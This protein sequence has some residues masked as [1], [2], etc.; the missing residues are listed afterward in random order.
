MN[1]ANAMTRSTGAFRPAWIVALLASLALFSSAAVV[2]GQRPAQPT[3]KSQKNEAPTPS[4]APLVPLSAASQPQ[5]TAVEAEALR[6]AAASTDKPL[7]G[8]VI[9]IEAGAGGQ[10]PIKDRTNLARV[11]SWTRATEAKANQRVAQVAQAYLEH[12]GAKVV[13]FYKRRAAN[14]PEAH[15]GEPK[16]DLVLNINHSYSVVPSENVTAAYYCPGDNPLLEAAARRINEALSEALGIPGTGPLPAPR[17]VAEKQDAPAVLL[18]LSLISNPDEFIHVAETSY[19]LRE[20]EAI[21]RG[22]INFARERAGLLT[23]G[24]PGQQLGTAPPW[25]LPPM[26]LAAAL[27]PPRPIEAVSSPAAS[28]IAGLAPSPLT[29]RKAPEAVQP[30]RAPAP[31]PGPTATVTLLTPTPG[32]SPL[33]TT[34]APTAPAKKPET[35]VAASIP[36]LIPPA[37]G[38]KIPGE[39]SLPPPRSK[40][41]TEPI[42]LVLPGI[43]PYEEPPTSVDKTPLADVWKPPAAKAGEQFALATPGPATSAT[44]PPLSPV[45]VATPTPKKPAP[46]ASPT[47][48][49]AVAPATPLPTPFE[50]AAATPPPPVALSPTPPA[51]SLA[52]TALGA[53]APK[54]AGPQ[55]AGEEAEGFFPWEPLFLNPVN[56]PIDQTWL[57]GEQ[58]E[59]NPLKRGVSFRTPAGTPVRAVADGAVAAVNF[60]DQPTPYLPFPRSVLIEHVE[61]IRGEKVYTMYGQMAEVSATLGQKVK[62]GDLIGRTGAPFE[63]S[64]GVRN[65]ELEFEIRI[66]GKGSE[67]ARNPELF[68]DHQAP[69]TGMIAGRIVDGDFRSLPGRRI[70]GL[71]NRKPEKTHPYYTYSLSYDPGVS[72]SFWEENFVIGDVLPG[73][74]ELRFPGGRTGTDLSKTV[75]VQPGKIAYVTVVDS[76]ASQ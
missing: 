8:Y 1:D 20:A 10:A 49:A 57:F 76:S 23:A 47:P 27:P 38:P 66:G 67:Y 50:V 4:V 22:A 16:V 13:P 35:F 44:P 53:P 45:K 70:D 11:D 43:E 34:K 15:V 75:T 2:F 68:I 69:G 6:Q 7:S 58:Y 9:G 64:K 41:E 55:R 71:E 12:A 62:A 32:L 51:A 28:A 3:P 17:P 73:V 29:E 52:E 14:A 56:A 61:P 39:E 65:S 5:K 33:T 19:N 54:P 24:M 72:P 30:A 63:L 26:V 59:T 40:S 60:G 48:K 42:R 31:S 25:R 46:A 37:S 18:V 74:Y 21:M 36:G